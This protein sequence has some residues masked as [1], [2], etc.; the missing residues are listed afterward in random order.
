MCSTRSSRRW[1]AGP[2]GRTGSSAQRTGPT[3]STFCCV[4][5]P[6]PADL[7]PPARRAVAVVDPQGVPQE[8][9]RL[10]RGQLRLFGQDTRGS[11]SLELISSR[12]AST[13]SWPSARVLMQIFAG[14]ARS[15]KRTRLWVT[16]KRPMRRTTPSLE[17]RNHWV[18]CPI[19]FLCYLE[20]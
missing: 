16:R 2:R 9:D 11:G 19:L 15:R 20:F 12:S 13:P 3:S 5:D 8:V 10:A 6:R 1:T 18:C 17:G 7:H 4:P 14:L